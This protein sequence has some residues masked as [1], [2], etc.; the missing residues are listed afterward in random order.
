MPR[1]AAHGQLPSAATI[2]GIMGMGSLAARRVLAVTATGALAA[3]VPAAA[4]QAAPAAAA[5][6][7]VAPAAVAPAA[8]APA[9]VAPAAVAKTL[10]Y[11]AN[12][13]SG[14]ISVIDTATGQVSATIPGAV[15]A[16]PYG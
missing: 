1:A 5:P 13:D 14:D 9:A 4:S 10:A 7:A 12:Y 11:V 8:V 15:G 2:G 16:S 3:L 6:A